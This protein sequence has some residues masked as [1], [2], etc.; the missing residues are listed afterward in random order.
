M[1][2]PGSTL[3]RVRPL[4]ALLSPFINRRLYHPEETRLS[5]EETDLELMVD[6]IALRG[7]EVNPGQK[8]A[9]VYYGGN[10]EG[11]DG[12]A[13][14]L[15]EWFPNHTSYLVAYRGYGASEGKPSERLITT[16]ALAVFKHA[17]ARHRGA[18]DVVGRSLGSAVAM[19]VAARRPVRRLVL[20]TPFDSMAALAAEDHPRLPVRLML[21]DRWDS[22]AVA[23]RLR[24]SVLVVRA[25]RDKVV[26][27]AATHRLVAA[28]PS[29][30][31]VL[32]LSQRSHATVDVDPRF[33][34]AIV[35]FLAP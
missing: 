27:P 33:W 28:L 21:R 8:H 34:P 19:Q 3:I 22:A 4:A 25:G 6:G 32:N 1:I 30:P 2:K 10:S 16:D 9:L 18:V 5:A 14:E 26:S 20:I 15:E 24:A 7:W 31:Q 29:E 12:L 11:L 13:E 35:E 17:A 23:H